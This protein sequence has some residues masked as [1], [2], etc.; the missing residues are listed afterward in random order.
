MI[1][2]QIL[3]LLQAAFPNQAIGDVAATTGG[4]SN[5]TAIVTIGAE[6]CAIKAAAAPLKRD[7]VR[8]EA[9]MLGLLQASGLPIPTLLAIIEDDAWTIAVTR[10]IAGEHGLRV[11][12]RAPEELEPLYLALGQLLARV[13]RTPLA[14]D[15]PLLADRARHALAR[16]PTLELEHDLG[17][18]LLAALEHP[19]WHARPRGLAHGDTG[20]HNLLWDGRIAALL[21]WEWSGWGTPLLDLAWLY[22]TIQWRGLPPALWQAFLAGYGDGP[23]LANGAPPEALRALALG[24]VASILTRAQSQPGAWE[25]WRRRLRWTIGLAFPALGDR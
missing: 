23:A 11:L 17:A 19:I 20:L 6:R 16:I 15:E 4:F 10:W 7:D 9:Q 8:R 13:H 5:L 18:A 1:P 21:D 2:A 24:Q 22:W 3:N 14:A 25:E 12:E